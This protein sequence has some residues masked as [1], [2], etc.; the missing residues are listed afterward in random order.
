V[1]VY[2]RSS[3]AVASCSGETAGDRYV[4]RADP[5]SWFAEAEVTPSIFSSASV[6][7]DEH[8]SQCIPPTVND[9]S[10]SADRPQPAANTR[11]AMATIATIIRG[12]VST[13]YSLLSIAA[14]GRRQPRLATALTRPGVFTKILVVAS[15]ALVVVT[16]LMLAVKPSGAPEVLTVQKH[17]Q[18][19]FDGN[20]QQAAMS[21]DGEYA[22][23]LSQTNG[24]HLI[25]VLETGGR[26][27]ITIDSV[28]TFLCCLS[29]SP[30]G[31]QLLYRRGPRGNGRGVIVPRLG[32]A[33][34]QLRTDV[35]TAWAP[36]GARVVSW[37]PQAKRLWLTDVALG[38]TTGSISIGDEHEWVLG[39]DWSPSG[40][41][42]AFATAA[43]GIV[44]LKTVRDDGGGVREVLRDSVGMRTPRWAA[45]GRAIY[46]ARGDEIWK[47]PVNNDGIRDGAPSVLLSGMSIYVWNTSVPAYSVSLDGTRLLYVKG[48]GYSNLWRF[49]P[50]A[51]GG[52]DVRVRALL[53]PGTATR[54]TPR[55]SPDGQ[56]VAFVELVAGTRNLVV[57]PLD[58]GEKRQLTFLDGGVWYPAWA[59]DG[60]RIVFGSRETGAP[61]LWIVDVESGAA[62][63]LGQN[64]YDGTG[65]IAWWPSSHIIYELED[66]QEAYLFD[67]ETGEDR[68]FVRAEEHAWLYDP[69]PSP[70]G[71]SV[72]FRRT[73]GAEV[74]GL[75]IINVGDT[76]LQEVHP[77]ITSPVG[78][79]AD[80][81]AVLAMQ[82]DSRS[83][84][85]REIFLIPVNGQ[86]AR[87]F[88]TF[89]PLYSSNPI[90]MSIT[91]DGK[92]LVAAVFN[93]S[94]DVWMVDNFDPGR[95]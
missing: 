48:L 46:V 42:L 14:S 2:P 19:T 15:L 45:D 20:V 89:P 44:T 67:P 40:H 85:A 71:N 62:R 57:M 65:D 47:V 38:D 41:R 87:P 52:E 56:W 43:G 32:G 55:I 59:P 26:S 77:A 31:S 73:G 16:L 35:V 74:R 18:L 70:D 54:Y 95:E 68:L 39:V 22:A 81:G 92:H 86:E 9:A 49:A 27:A 64:R 93:S 91:P 28:D 51:A 29:W 6:M 76:L 12:S 3:I 23:V 25:K 61:G 1:T 78:W 53:T 60:K 79:S 90:N 94:Q 80:G 21:P 30:D 7:A 72:A 58:G 37:W 84:A 11:A 34:R 50:D 69:R 88:F 8:P 24:T 82:V 10:T 36:D 66:D 5:S 17:T 63:A 33:G 75:T 13:I 83:S 4:A